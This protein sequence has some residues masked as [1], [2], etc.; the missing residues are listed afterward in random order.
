MAPIL[1]CIADDVTGASDLA[2]ALSVSGMR[3]RLWFGLHEPRNQSID[4][5]AVV[6][7]L[8]T[9]SIAPNDAVLQS[10]QA[11]DVLRSLGAKRFLFKY[12][13]TFDSTAQG[14]IG[15]VAEALMNALDAKCTLFCPTTPENGR[16]VYCGHLFVKGMLL[17]R[18]GMQ[19][20]P[21]NPM[22]ESDLTL[23]LQQQ[24]RPNVGL[25]PYK[26]VSLGAAAITQSIRS[27]EIQQR[28][29]LVV[30][31]INQ[32]DLQSIAV[33]A[34]QM[35]LV[36]SGSG[37]ATALPSAYHQAGILASLQ[38]SATLPEAIGSALILSGSCSTAT[39][40]QVQSWSETGMAFPMDVAKLLSG[41]LKLEQ[42]LNWAKQTLQNNDAL[43]Y[44]TSSPDAVKQLQNEFGTERTSA[45]I[46]ETMGNLARALVAEG[47]RKLIVA[48]GE[49]SG[50]V[51]R[52]LKIDQVR[53]GPPIAPG[54]PWMETTE[55]PKLAIALKSG[56]FG[57]DNFFRSA[58]EMLS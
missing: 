21:L 4:A 31:A 16:T 5:D 13:S 18:S 56:N 6:I 37:L 26:V 2:N 55:E 58:L 50:A 30:D 40:R 17:D 52:A 23:V 29:F 47:V 12:C 1:G 46:E 43:I 10:L 38:Q 42:I 53:I 44:T 28:S 19:S 27:H 9:R 57:D 14:N 33:V 32:M 34:A 8:K 51:V 25:I 15:P 45:A 7:A 22:T 39:Q 54:V 41:E 48:G 24:S 20:H 3:T 36:T 35:P 49:T 11:L